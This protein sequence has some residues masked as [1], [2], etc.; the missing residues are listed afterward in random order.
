M[1]NWTH[2]LLLRRA[3]ATPNYIFWEI[4]SRETALCRVWLRF[5]FPWRG[6]PYGHAVFVHPT[7]FSRA[8]LAFEASLIWWN[9]RDAQTEDVRLSRTDFT[10]RMIS[11]SLALLYRHGWW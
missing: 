11:L 9:Y 1:P 7:P 6:R 10:N 2:S 4:L 8:K 5:G 3:A